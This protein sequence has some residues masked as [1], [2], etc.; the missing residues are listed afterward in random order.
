M[1]KKLFFVLTICILTA[2]ALV[3]LSGCGNKKLDNPR[4]LFITDDEYFTWNEVEGADGYIVYFNDNESKRFYITDNY[5]SVDQPEILSSLISGQTNRIYIR[6]VTLDANK[7]PDK[8]S[9][10]SM[11]LFNYV[12][13]LSTPNKVAMKNDQFSWKSVAGATDYKAMVRRSGESEGKLYDMNWRTGT[14]SISGDIKD[15]PNGYLYYVSIVATAEGYENSEPSVEVPFDRTVVNIDVTTYTAYI[16]ELAYP[17]VEDVTNADL[18]SV[19]VSANIGD[20]IVIKD[21]TGKSYAVTD[22]FVTG[23]G[24]YSIS[25][26]KQSGSARATTL[27]TYYI[28]VNG[29]ETGAKL[30]YNSATGIYYANVTLSDADTY[31]IKD[32]AGTLLTNYTEDSAN[33]GIAYTGGKFVITIDADARISVSE[34]TTPVITDNTQAVDGKWP[35][36]F[37]YNYL[38]APQPNVVYTANNRPVLTP[39]TPVRKGYVFDGW[40]EDTHCLIAAEFGPKQSNFAITS[41]TTLYAGWKV[42]VVAPIEH[43]THTDADVDGICDVCG[44]TLDIIVC[45]SHVDA[46]T[47]GKCDICG[48]TIE[49]ECD[50]HVDEDADGKCDTCG[51]TMPDVVCNQHFDLNGD[52][53]CNACGRPVEVQQDTEADI[54]F[55]VSSFP[56]FRAD[57]AV[58]NVHIWYTDGSNNTFPG[59]VMTYDE[60]TGYYVAKYYSSKTIKGV[61]FTRNDPN[62]S[63]SEGTKTEW[64]RV[65]VGEFTFDPSRP[66]YKLTSYYHNTDADFISFDGA[67]LQVGETIYDDGEDRLY[68][69]FRNLEWFSDNSPR[70]T[71]YV[72]YTDGGNNAAFPG[73]DVQYVTDN[74]QQKVYACYVNFNAT[75]QVAGA[76]LCRLDPATGDIWNKIEL[77]FEDTPFDKDKT[78]FLISSLYGSVAEGEWVTEEA[79]LTEPSEE[80][81]PVE[82]QEPQ[83]PEAPTI[84][85]SHGATFYLKMSAIDWFENDGA[86]ISALI[87]YKDGSVNG[88]NIGVTCLR[89]NGVYKWDYNPLK[90][91]SSILILR[92]DPKTQAVWNSF[93]LTLSDK[94]DQNMIVV[95]SFGDTVSYE[96]ARYT[97]PSTDTRTLY[98]TNTKGWDN[99]KA[100]VWVS[101]NE[102]DNNNWPGD[103]CTYV[104][105]NNMGQNVYSITISAS[106]DRIIFNNGSGGGDNQTENIE[107]VPDSSG[108][109][110]TD[111][112]NGDG[113]WMVGTWTYSD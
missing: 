16:G 58:I 8:K 9:D 25:F 48:K 57:N 72:W 78:A 22:G 93:S 29:S 98:F 94:A 15:L 97:E 44:K 77:S 81:E 100:Y 61:L 83:E 60:T 68:F 82:P 73:K 27:T 12:R 56:Q 13:Q 23:S 32:A 39:A 20:N 79:T 59:A 49:S 46:N 86:V 18:Y 35:V 91:I 17:L 69:D 54:Y 111:N 53:L 101:D 65:E 70:L 74:T 36:T 21:N 26:D 19:T 104:M 62:G 3:A 67:W 28:Y 109:Y 106:Y 92:T 10:R 64:D 34:T 41:P 6:A 63:P 66:V 1:K 30:S 87:T 14:V 108:F 80:S 43:T 110:A 55:D 84:D 51:Q 40:Y 75:K 71:I 103:T 42:D 31:T 7:L 105:T 85:D 5:I 88:A 112:K 45:V 96:Y 107:I 4:G 76:I 90:E 102:S 11:I 99:V 38:N 33:S 37:D 50:S 113:N 2:A 24:E 95:K 89:D 47:D 52:G